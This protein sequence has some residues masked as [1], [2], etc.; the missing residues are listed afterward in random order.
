MCVI[1]SSCPLL[2]TQIQNVNNGEN[3]EKL[4]KH[5]VCSCL[6]RRFRGDLFAC[7]CCSVG[8]FAFVGWLLLVIIGGC[9]SK[10]G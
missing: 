10:A 4:R 3:S 1:V 2:L 6:S 5:L 9:W 7:K 8:S